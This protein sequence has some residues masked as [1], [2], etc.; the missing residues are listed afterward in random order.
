MDSHNTEDNGQ[1]DQEI[2]LEE[3]RLL[4]GG[5]PFS[6]TASVVIAFIIFTVFFLFTNSIVGK[7]VGQRILFNEFIC[8]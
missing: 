8:Y 5:T 3:I 4:Y 7:R 6:Y 1:L 2:R